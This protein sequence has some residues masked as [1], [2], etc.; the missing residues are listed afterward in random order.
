MV[1]PIRSTPLL[2]LRAPAVY[3]FPWRLHGPK[4]KA[5]LP[6]SY[7][8]GFFSPPGLIT[9][10]MAVIRLRRT[11]SWLVLEHILRTGIRIKHGFFTLIVFHKNGRPIAI[12]V[13]LNRVKKPRF[14]PL[15]ELRALWW[16]DSRLEMACFIRRRRS[17]YIHWSSGVPAWKM[18]SKG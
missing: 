16:S 10:I 12:Y 15:A 8:T 18:G 11:F 13:A 2:P 7:Y 1:Y 5:S 17:K 9:Y 14:L 4:S 3:A 6:I